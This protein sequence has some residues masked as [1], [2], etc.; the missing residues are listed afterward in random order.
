MYYQQNPQQVITCPDAYCKLQFESPDQWTLH[1][2]DARHGL[3]IVLPSEQLRMLFTQHDDTLQHVY[4]RADNAFTRMRTAWG[5]PDSPQRRDA[6]HAFL[7]QL[8]SDPL[9]TSDKPPKER[10]FGRYYQVDMNLIST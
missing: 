2:T 3:D 6:E 1:A 8:D 9:Y 10:S 4:P 5:E 7:D